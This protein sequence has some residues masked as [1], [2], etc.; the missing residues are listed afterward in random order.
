MAKWVALF[1]AGLIIAGLAYYY[2][3]TES[4]TVIKRVNPAESIARNPFSASQAWLKQRGQPTRHILSAASLFPLP[5]TSTTL[6]IDSQR[7]QLSDQQREALLEWVSRGGHLVLEA[8][9][10]SDDENGGNH[11]DND[12]LLFDLGIHILPRD[13]H[14]SDDEDLLYDVIDALPVFVD[15]LLEACLRTDNEEIAER[16]LR[17]ACE[18]PNYPAPIRVR[19]TLHD[20]EQRWRQLG[21]N[22]PVELWHD[23]FDYGDDYV[24]DERWPTTVK[25][26]VD[27]DEASQLIQL[28][29][30]DGIVTV[31]SAF[32]LWHNDQLHLFDNAWLLATL[33]GTE[34]VWF[35]RS[36]DMPPLAQWLWQRAPELISGL[37]FAF[38][39]WLW[40]RIRRQGPIITLANTEHHDYLHHLKARGYFQWRTKQYIPLL[41]DLRKQARRFL[42]LLH[43]EEKKA[44]QLAAARLNITEQD[45]QD[46]LHNTPA[47][48]D[49]F[50]R[51]VSTLQ[52]L[53]TL[54]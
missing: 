9:N 16:C 27:S 8:G 29:L 30:R 43:P 35:V 4:I 25:T 46:A 53:R 21:I 50:V 1:L 18:A 7:S 13:N 10:A 48:R 44:R 17:F 12:P 6:V 19:E 14:S 20:G 32:T 41:K 11:Q 34:P 24:P 36:T 26:Y 45:I 2:S 23:S 33:T 3:N 38:L 51:Y 52:A 31:Q 47:S 5:D 15:G 54:L 22:E 39:L 42:A 28:S 49:A 40:S 37:F